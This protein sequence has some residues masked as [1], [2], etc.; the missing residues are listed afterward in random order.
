MLASA[1]RAT[2]PENNPMADN[3]SRPTFVLQSKVIWANAAL[4][5][6]VHYHPKAGDWVKQNPELSVYG[7]L[8]LNAVL[9]HLTAEGIRYIPNW[10]RNS[11]PGT[12]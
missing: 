9:R 5:L 4:A 6:V 10:L 11:L 12:T 2:S 1:Q 7:V 3:E 8:V